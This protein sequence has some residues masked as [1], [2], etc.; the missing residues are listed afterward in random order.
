MIDPEQV[1]LGQLKATLGRLVPATARE[2]FV[3]GRTN[4]RDCAARE[5]K[6]SLAMAEQLIDTMVA[7]G[8]L[9]FEEPAAPGEFGLWR[10]ADD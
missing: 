4:L 7:R 9:R 6:C 8:F 1:D 3:V 5:L 2:G 10:V